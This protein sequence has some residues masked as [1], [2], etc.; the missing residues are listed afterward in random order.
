[1]LVFLL[2]NAATYTYDSAAGTITINGEGAYIGLAKANNQGELPN[3][4][5]PSA[6]T[7]QATLSDGN[8]T[9]NVSIEIGV[10]SGVFWQYK[11]VKQ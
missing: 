8:T 5:V 11:L 2:S 7:Y 10:G 1:M 9:M 3:V 6:I 4:A